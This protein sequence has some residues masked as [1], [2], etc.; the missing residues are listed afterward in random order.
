[1]KTKQDVIQWL[2]DN[3]QPF[4]EMADAI[5][6]R[7]EIAFNEFYAAQLQADF[8]EKQGFR[9]QRDVAG[10]NTA[11]IAEWGAGRPLIG[12]AGEYDALPA[13]SQKCQTTRAAVVEGG[14]GH[15]C[16]HNLLGTGRS[17][18]R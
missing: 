13:L 9:V 5:W 17:S 1:M 18:T 7:P 14:L 15:G 2:E 4:I 11:F 12:F 16:G 3:R 10:M 6:Q 8:L